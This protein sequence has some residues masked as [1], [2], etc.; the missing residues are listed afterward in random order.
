MKVAFRTDASSDIGTGH[1][2]RCL[3]LADALRELGAQCQ[4]IC[5]EHDG[6]LIDLI[7]NRGHAVHSL[8]KPMPDTSLVS[9][10]AHSCWLGVAWETDAE[11]TFKLLGAKNYDWLVVDHYGLDYRWEALLRSSCNRV[12][13]IDD[14]ADRRHDCDLLLDQNVIGYPER[15]QGLVSADCV[16]CHGPSYA[17]L[18][19]IYLKQRATLRVRAGPVRRA[20]IFLGGG[21]SIQS[22]TTFVVMEFC[23]KELEGI[24]LDVVIGSALDYESPLRD[25][26]SQRGYATIHEQLPNLAELMAE[27]D[28]AIGA[29]GSTTWERCC[30]GLPSLVISVAEN[31]RTICETLASEKVIYYLGHIDEITPGVIKS[32]VL[33]LHQRPDILQSLSD[34]GMD[35]VDGH[36]ID[37][38][39]KEIYLGV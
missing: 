27:A 35:I 17:L 24:Q 21:R 16:Q 4:F 5:R 11:Q 7:L 38:I 3:T 33:L 12:M 34:N 15:Y 18:N 14:L 9:D 13:A 30:L 1:V 26:V 31:Q 2:I 25:V 19:P 20:L 29:G 36:G 28:F 10:L 23:N 6:H 37:R 39:T 22:F 8:P 32:H